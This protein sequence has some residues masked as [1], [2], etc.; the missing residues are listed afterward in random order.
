LGF[1]TFAIA[2]GDMNG[3]GIPDLVLTSNCQ[4]QT[5]LNGYV[6]VLLQNP[7]GSF[8]Y[9]IIVAPADGGPIALA[10]MNG[11]GHLD[12]VFNGG[13]MLNDG[14]NDWI[15]NTLSGGELVGGAVSIAVGD[16]N[17]D[18]K[19]DVVEVTD[20]NQVDVLLGN[21]D[22]TLQPPLKY[23]TGGFWPLDVT[24][25]NNLD[26]AGLPDLVVSNECEFTQKGSGK[27]RC[28]DAGYV[29]LLTNKGGVGPAFLGFN[30]ARVFPSGAYAASSTAVADINGDGKPDLVIAN[31]CTYLSSS[32]VPCTSDGWVQVMLNN[33]S[34]ATA[35]T[36][37]AAPPSPVYVNQPV[38]L[39]ATTTSLGSPSVAIA[40]NTL[41]TFYQGTTPIGT[42]TTNNGVANLPTLFASTGVKYLKATFAGDTWN[43]QSSGT[44]NLSV[45]LWPTTTSV[46]TNP[47]TW[48]KSVPV[49]ITATVSS[50]APGGA[51]GS[52]TFKKGSATLGSAPLSGGVASLSY[53]F[54]STGTFTITA[55]Y[56]GDT[57]SA[58]SS[59]TITQTVAP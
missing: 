11:D 9:P 55:N 21:G 53:A 27:G 36:L 22:G 31:L 34:I 24:I 50:S 48:T 49:L 4:L 18:G 38:T 41:V 35:T 29:S 1:E 13:V 8:Q 45:A 56:S 20:L 40:N 47:S 10:D 26:G 39:T 25:A 59:G 15:F 17:G 3:D 28:S 42:G 44:L 37:A 5:C 14:L 33:T 58:K 19:P 23:K 46:T 2:V 6:T 7:N 32:A 52:V 12:I 16:V 54:P 51:T 57:Q 30:A 43:A